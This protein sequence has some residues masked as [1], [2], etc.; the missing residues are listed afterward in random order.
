MRSIAFLAALAL[1]APLRA[2][3]PDSVIRLLEQHTLPAVRIASQ[4]WTGAPLAQRLAYYHTP[5]VS[6]AVMDSGKIVWARA[7]GMADQKA[8]RAATTETLFQAASISKPL[9]ATAALSLVEEGRLSLDADV[10][11][12]LKSWQVPASEHAHG[13]PVTLRRLVT[14]TAGLTIH[15]FPGYARSAKIPTAVQVLRGEGN[16]KSV[17]VDTTPGSRWNYSGGGYTVTQVLLG[18]VTG[19]PFATLMQQRVLGAMHLTRSTYQQPLPEARWGEAATG[20]RPSGDPVEENWHVY[21][22]QAAAGLWTTPTDLATWGL[23]ILAAYNGTTGGVLSPTMAKQMLTPGLGNY[24]LGPAIFPDSKSFGHGG[25]NEGFRCQITVFFDGRGV[26]VMTNSDAGGNV[27]REVLTTLAAAYGWPAFT[28]VEKTVA[29]LPAATLAEIAGRYRL[30]D[31]TNNVVVT[32]EGGRLFLTHPA[33]GRV[34]LLPQSDSSL[35]M[36]DDGTTFTVVRENG[37]VAAI[38][39]MGQRAQRVTP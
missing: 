7:W 17:V 5:A 29:Q 16:T 27:I 11:Q 28:P 38:E 4:P 14:H 23:A 8:G 1:A 36:R 6:V 9:T 22:E 18:D 33:F 3:S 37:Q 25:A 10:N 31:D 13:Q 35:F 12:Y 2:Q 26:A 32:L 34:E 39:A 30:P 15:G 20:Y 21:P 24:G 19:L